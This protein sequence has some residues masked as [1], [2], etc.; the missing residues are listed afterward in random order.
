MLSL[1]V[2][3]PENLRIRN[4]SS[5]VAH[6]LL[7][8]S[9]VVLCV[10]L[11]LV[12]LGSLVFHLPVV[13]VQQEERFTKGLGEGVQTLIAGAP[14]AQ[15]LLTCRTEVVGSVTDIVQRKFL[16]MDL[17]YQ[18]LKCSAKP[19]VCVRCCF[20]ALIPDFSGI[21]FKSALPNALGKGLQC[22]SGTSL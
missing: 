1:A 12:L 15:V 4:K 7:Y 20:L 2:F 13:L 17:C 8:L 6:C 10:C 3:F 21:L 19:I 18:A 9:V 5:P 11:A 14:V 16:S 22:S